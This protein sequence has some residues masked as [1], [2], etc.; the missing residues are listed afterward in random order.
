[1]RTHLRTAGSLAAAAGLAATLTASLSAPA[2]AMPER[3]T[4]AGTIVQCDGEGGS[5]TAIDTTL[6][7][8]HWSGGMLVG[9]TYAHAGGDSVLY[10]GTSLRGTFPAY[11]DA[12][13]LELGEL[14][15]DGALARGATETVSG[16]DVDY[17]GRRKQTEGTRTPLSGSV[18][19]T[20]AGA[21]TSL[22]CIG[23]EFDLETF[24]LTSGEPSTLEGGWLPDSHELGEG[25]GTIMFYGEKQHELGIAVDLFDPT[26]V[27]GGERLQIRNGQVEGSLL[28]RDPETWAVVGLVTV[29][30][31][32]TET[33]R[34]RT[35]ARRQG[36]QRAID[37]V[38]YDVT[39][40]VSSERG[41][42]S[43]TWAAT[44]E[45]S[46]TLDVIPPRAV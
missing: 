9:D 26:Y 39:L 38:H 45:T 2:Q 28:L 17:D 10:D 21:A 40:T 25:A 41:E 16:W 11:D 36:W 18:R 32:V 33:G 43:G 12:T 23:L 35:V 46:R 7:G 30:G 1:M 37:L 13:G 31:T 34:E 44:H 15:I 42:W 19:L 20:L 29:S 22:D 14:G 6:A 8:T 27:F 5:L 4:D 24:Q 3:F